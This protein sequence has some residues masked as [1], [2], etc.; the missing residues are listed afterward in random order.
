MY[1]PLKL[2]PDS[3]TIPLEDFPAEFDKSIAQAVIEGYLDGLVIDKK[4]RKS[5]RFYYQ[6]FIEGCIKSGR[7]K[8]KGQAAQ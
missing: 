5:E 4:P 1:R 8:V 6:G 3:I 7:I 2:S